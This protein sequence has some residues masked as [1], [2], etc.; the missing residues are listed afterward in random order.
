MPLGLAQDFWLYVKDL[1]NCKSPT[2]YWLR[3]LTLANSLEDELHR[4]QKWGKENCSNIIIVTESLKKY[5]L[6]SSHNSGGFR[7]GKESQVK[8][9]MQ[10]F[11]EM[12]L[13]IQQ[14]FIA[15]LQCIWHFSRM[16]N[17]IIIKQQ[18]LLF[19]VNKCWFN[20]YMV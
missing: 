20:Q 9:P 6:K 16:R 13:F 4:D 14:I 19:I 11:I 12:Y 8:N 3:N 10:E 15:F 18:S 7:M 5:A 1:G 2:S 17:V